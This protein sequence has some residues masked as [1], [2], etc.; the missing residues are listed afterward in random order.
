MRVIIEKN[1]EKMSE[2][3]ADFIASQVRRKPN[4][5]LG[6][7][8]G[9]TP[10][11][12]YKELI[13]R[14]NEENLDF[15]HVTTFNLDEYYGLPASHPQSYYQ[16]MKQNFFDHINISFNRVHIPNGMV[17]MDEVD[18]YC[19]NYE[20]LMKEAGGIDLQLLGIGG[21]GHIGFNEPGS[22][23]GSRTRIKTLGQE[24]R[25][26]D[27]RFFENDIEKVPK[28]ALTMGVATI[29]DARTCLMLASG[30]GKAEAVKQAIEGPLTSQTTGS[31][32]QLHSHA[33]AIIDE[34]AASAL[35]RKDYYIYTEKMRAELEGDY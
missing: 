22:S 30:K 13:R 3:A 2:K 1:Y 31:A 16:Y 32:L 6:L 35:E 27:S 11:G 7:P 18:A 14:Y 10:I 29:L 28:A 20:E 4:S 21:N 17:R 19:A 26:D 33:I 12:T 34:D 9:G 25:K 5:V 8:T 24:T 15:A 23:L